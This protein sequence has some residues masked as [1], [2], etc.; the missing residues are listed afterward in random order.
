M[1]RH[2]QLVPLHLL[3]EL[4]GGGALGVCPDSVYQH[5][6]HWPLDGP[7]VQVRRQVFRCIPSVFKLR[8]E[9]VDDQ[10]NVIDIRSFCMQKL[11]CAKTTSPDPLSAMLKAARAA[12]TIMAGKMVGCA[13]R[14]R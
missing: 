2:V 14:K 12:L 4:E 6:H 7:Q 10:H 3:H 5:L 8:E 9:C 13:A 1:L 11:T